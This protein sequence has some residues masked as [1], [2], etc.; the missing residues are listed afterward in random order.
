MSHPAERREPG[1]LAEMLRLS[2]P[3][4]IIKDLRKKIA[5]LEQLLMTN[6]K[7]IYRVAFEY[8]QRAERL[9]AFV[10]KLKDLDITKACEEALDARD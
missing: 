4:E 10:R 7:L 5:R 6:D 3:Q 2:S 9:E 8:Y 1:F